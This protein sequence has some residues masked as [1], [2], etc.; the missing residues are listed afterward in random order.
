MALFPDL[1]RFIRRARAM[2]RESRCEILFILDEESL[3]Y[4]NEDPNMMGGHHTALA[5]DMATE[6][7]LCGAPVEQYRLRDLMEMDLSKYRMLVFA[8]AFCVDRAMRECLRQRLAP[9][10]HCAFGTTRR[11]FGIPPLPGTTCGI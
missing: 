2:K 5:D 11:G 1:L 7:L 9:G 4:Q 3:Y 10:A 6:L 8:N